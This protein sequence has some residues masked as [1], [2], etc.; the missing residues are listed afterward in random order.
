LGRE[1]LA[2]SLAGAGTSLLV[3]A[4]GTVIYLVLGVSIGT[5][6]GAT[7]GW[8]DAIL[9]R[10]PE[11]VL[12]LPA[13]YPALAVRAQLPAGMPFW[14]TAMLTAALIAS[15][16]WPPLARVVR[17]LILQIRGAAYVD[18]ARSMGASR[19]HI[20][21]H[22]VLS[23]VWPMTW[24][25]TVVAAPIFILG[26]V[27]LSFLNVG[28]HDS[29]SRGAMLREL[30]ADPRILTDFWWIMAPLAL[31]FVTLLCLNG[32]GRPLRTKTPAQ[33]A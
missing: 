29:S 33:L 14:Q 27:M 20:F 1:V 21:C 31:V 19:W 32:L 8:I 3:L 28:F 23:A 24:A 12:A 5:L 30:M 2:R 9:M 13:L 11:F 18:A 10:F 6:A 25:Q 4:I 17:G 22:H 7:G 26:E 15:I 16:A